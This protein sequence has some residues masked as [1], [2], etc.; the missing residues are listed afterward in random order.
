M[1]AL[2]WMAAPLFA[3]APAAAPRPTLAGTWVPSDP[4]RSDELFA[5]GLAVTPGG[6]RLTI[7]QR[8][9]R[10]TVTIAMPD[11]KLDPLLRVNG[12]FYTTIIYR[13]SGGRSGGAGA[14]GPQSPSGPTWFGDRLVIPDAR[15]AARQ[16]TVTY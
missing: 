16:T 14:G 11:D 2:C 6:G 12:R 5:V 7:E 3:Q 4:K 15:P 9:D 10:L 13:L 1:A 8:A